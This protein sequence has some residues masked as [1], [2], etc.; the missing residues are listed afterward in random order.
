MSSTYGVE[1][2]R[3]RRIGEHGATRFGDAVG[4]GECH[5]CIVLLRVKSRSLQ[6]AG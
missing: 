5:P 6:I 1:D 3:Q 4:I 2:G